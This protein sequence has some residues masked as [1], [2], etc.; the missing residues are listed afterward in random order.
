MARLLDKDIEAL[1]AASDLI[2]L[3][4]WENTEHWPI[5]YCSDNAVKLL[6]YSKAELERGEIKFEDLVH[7]ED[8]KRVIGEVE[9]AIENQSI[10]SF[11]HEDYRLFKRNGEV[12]WVAD[13][14]ILERSE[15]GE[16]E[17]LTGHIIDIT[18]RKQ[19]ELSLSA[20]R[21]YLSRVITSARLASWDWDIKA[22]TVKFNENC[23]ALLG[24]K[25]EQFSDQ[26]WREWVHPHDIKNVETLV[27]EHLL[28]NSPYYN[29]VYRIVREDGT[30]LYVE[31]RGQVVRV[32]NSNQPAQMSGILTDISL[33]KKA[34]LAAQEHAEMRGNI[35]ANVSHEIRTP[36]HGILGLASV[37]E[38]EVRNPRQKQLLSTIR[39]S[40]DYLLQSLNDVLDLTRA[41]KG[42]LQ[43]NRSAED[44][45]EI[46]QHLK[47]LFSESLKEKALTFKCEIDDNVPQNLEIDRVRLLQILIN[48]VDN[49]IKYTPQ[50]SITVTFS[51][52]P[53]TQEDGDLEI[54]V[55]DTGVGIRDTERAWHLF[56]KE[57][58]G[59]TRGSGVGLS[60]VQQLIQ[61]LGGHVELMSSEEQGSEF[62]I[63]IPAQ[64][65]KLDALEAV[66]ERAGE[67]RKASVRALI[68]DD[69][70][71]NQLVL[72]E[73]LESLGLEFISASNGN[74][75]LE[76]MSHIDV[77]I[78]FMDWHMH[79][80]NGLETTRKIR[81]KYGDKPFIIGLT[82]NTLDSVKEQ[83]LS[84]GM[85]DLLT[86]PFTLN[87][88][89]NVVET[90]DKT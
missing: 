59:G 56:E 47:D 67:L 74:D 50:G 40:G 17:Y 32:D 31:D 57:S 68:V 65:S 27:Q 80:L 61:L 49:S 70:D 83:A 36:L 30:L 34:E 64:A 42:F 45:R 37:L 10:R 60:I 6:G 75:A 43:I 22:G 72:G 69:S 15:N 81:E 86:K 14:T 71:V 84:A 29:A 53:R 3:F 1:F 88:I 77:H 12:V 89:R 26:K 63:Y 2:T 20:E 11:T 19:L 51:W 9:S 39:K 33:H 87:E 62:H 48:L 85:N 13:T 38:T 54:K 55:K 46:G 24:V 73:M 90:F 82:A 5:N 66:V 58:E 16:V 28:G 18:E 23:Q 44:V 79:S 41:E 78:V 35:L 25:E 52:K 4:I 21:N 8:L 7:P 76:V